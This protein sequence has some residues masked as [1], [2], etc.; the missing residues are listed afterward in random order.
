MKTKYKLRG[1]LKKSEYT[2][3]EWIVQGTD[4][5]GAKYI[6]TILNHFQG[7]KVKITIKIYPEDGLN[8]EYGCDERED[9]RT[10]TTPDAETHTYEYNNGGLTT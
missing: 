8:S 3:P 7:K 6:N 1:R 9:K 5:D 2:S 4:N 10:L